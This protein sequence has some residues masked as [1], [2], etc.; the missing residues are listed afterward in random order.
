MQVRMNYG[1]EGL[2]LNLPDHWEVIVIEKK[3]MPLIADPAVAIAQ[4]LTQGVDCGSL[5]KEAK[6]KQNACIVICDITRPVPNGLLLPPG[7]NGV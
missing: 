4:A 6:G 1:R 5:A 3:P 7:H 2:T